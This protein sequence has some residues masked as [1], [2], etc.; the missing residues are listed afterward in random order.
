M[1]D[2]LDDRIEVRGLELLLYCGVLPEEQA[3]QQ[4]FLFDV[5]LYLDL[6]EAATTDNLSATADYGPLVDLLS[7]TLAEERFQLLERLA[8]RVTELVFEHAPVISAVTVTVRKIRPPLAAHV[9][10]TGVRVHRARP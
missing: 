3:R 1:P 6:T 5:D 2:H 4:P 9:D 8:A 7:T 10:T